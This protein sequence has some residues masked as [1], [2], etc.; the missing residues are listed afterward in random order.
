MCIRDSNRSKG[1]AARM[2]GG[3]NMRLPAGACFVKERHTIAKPADLAGLRFGA[4][5]SSAIQTLMPAWLQGNG[6]DPASVEQM[7]FHIGIHPHPRMVAEPGRLTRPGR[8]HPVSYTH[9]DVYKRQQ[10]G[11]ASG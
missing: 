8:P 4:G 3:I 6:V 11:A 5:Q 1:G 2:I 9:L 10:S 7:A